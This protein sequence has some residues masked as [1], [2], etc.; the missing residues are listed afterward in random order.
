MATSRLNV[1]HID[2]SKLHTIMK[3]VSCP[4]PT[5]ATYCRRAD[6]QSVVQR[7]VARRGLAFDL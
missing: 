3:L 5:V 6:L 1:P 7:S 2:H 4:V